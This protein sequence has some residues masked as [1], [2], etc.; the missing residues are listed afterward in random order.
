LQAL[1]FWLSVQESLPELQPVLQALP[2]SPPV[3]L[4]Q[5]LV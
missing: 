3:S 4:E 2:E 5:R 1:R